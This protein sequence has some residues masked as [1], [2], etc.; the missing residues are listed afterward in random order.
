MIVRTHKKSPVEKGDLPCYGRR[1][2]LFGR[3]DSSGLRV[4]ERNNLS[5]LDCLSGVALC[6]GTH[7]RRNTLDGWRDGSGPFANGPPVHLLDRCCRGTVEKNKPHP[8]ALKLP[9]SSWTPR[10]SRLFFF[11]TWE[12]TVK[13]TLGL[14]SQVF[15]PR[16]SVFCCQRM[17]ITM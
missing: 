6:G 16:L 7:A 17:K 4:R 14:P 12:N 8:E 15:R 10:F 5:E 1:R 9:L 2:R 13:C 3:H 11:R